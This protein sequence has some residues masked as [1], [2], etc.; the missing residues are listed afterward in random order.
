MELIPQVSNFLLSLVTGKLNKSQAAAVVGILINLGLGIYIWTG[1]LEYALA[2]AGLILLLVIRLVFNL[3]ADTP[4]VK[5]KTTRRAKRKSKQAT[6]PKRN[7]K[8]IMTV[9]LVWA[10]IAPLTNLAISRHQKETSVCAKIDPQM[11]PAGKKDEVLVVISDFPRSRDLPTNTLYPDDNLVATLQIAAARINSENSDFVVRVAKLNN[12]I[13][14]S[15]EE[16]KTLADC[17]NATLVVWGYVKQNEMTYVFSKTPQVAKKRWGNEPNFEII[18]SSESEKPDEFVLGGGGGELFLNLLISRLYFYT[19]LL[20]QALA[21]SDSA[22]NYIESYDEIPAKTISLAYGNRGVIR[23]ALGDNDRALSDFMKADAVDPGNAQNL[24]SIGGLYSYMGEYDLARKYL[25]RAIATD[26]SSSLA[27]F[28][29]GVLEYITGNLDNALLDY[30]IAHDLDPS[31]Y[32]VLTNRGIIHELLGDYQS[33]MND[34]ND[35][36]S[37]NPNNGLTY[38]SRGRTHEKMGNLAQ[39]SEDYRKAFELGYQP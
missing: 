16:A 14:N 7:W 32:F 31:L 3:T 28:N 1:K 38:Y 37:I 6:A 29:R 22:I 34:Y 18:T 21:Y 25:D 15:Q 23:S 33:A 4:A 13:I 19:D 10:L 2:P 36:I 8:A 9:V 26:R 24:S 39:A 11:K 27:Y 35:A 5:V 12:T 20:E 17:Y 30:S